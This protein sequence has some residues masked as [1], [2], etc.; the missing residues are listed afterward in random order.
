[1]TDDAGTDRR[2]LLGLLKT[3]FLFCTQMQVATLRRLKTVSSSVPMRL[4]GDCP[5]HLETAELTMH[6][7]NRFSRA[8]THCLADRCLFQRSPYPYPSRSHIQTSG[9]V[10]GVLLAEGGINTAEIVTARLSKDSLSQA[11]ALY[12]R[13]GARCTSQRFETNPDY[14]RYDCLP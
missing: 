2:S 6:L 7:W 10:P 8:V 4:N 3:E 13:K 5:T 9:V 12:A 11:T 14:Y 1:M